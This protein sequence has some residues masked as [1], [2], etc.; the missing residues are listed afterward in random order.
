MARLQLFLCVNM[1]T[2]LLLIIIYSVNPFQSIR[3]II[4]WYFWNMHYVEYVNDIEAITA[5]VTWADFMSEVS[6]RFSSSYFRN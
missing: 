4:D 1:I 5:L 6:K 3:S 2:S